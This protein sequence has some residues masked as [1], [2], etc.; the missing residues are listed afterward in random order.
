MASHAREVN[1]RIGQPLSLAGDVVA[2]LL[3]GQLEANEMLERG[4]GHRRTNGRI[5]QRIDRGIIFARL[6]LAGDAPAH[7]FRQG[8]LGPVDDGPDQNRVSSAMINESAKILEEGIASAKDIEIGMMMGDGLPVD[9][10]RTQLVTRS[11]VRTST[12]WARLGTYAI[13]P[14]GFLMTR[15]M[16]LGLKQRAEALG[17]ASM[18]EINPGA[19]SDKRRVA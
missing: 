4:V 11:C 16:L 7:V 10:N 13:E 18:G 15:R 19:L 8:R 5:G 6:A 1:A 9:E 14:A 12:V 2:E 3:L 17:G